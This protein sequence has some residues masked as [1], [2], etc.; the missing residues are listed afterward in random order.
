MLAAEAF[1]LP[2][3]ELLGHVVHAAAPVAALK[4]SGVHAVKLPPSGPVYPIEATQAVLAVEPV[5]PPLAEFLGQSKHAAAPVAALKVSVAHAVKLP[6]SGPV[7]PIEAL[8]AVLVE[9]LVTPSVAELLGHAEQAAAPVAALKESTVQA[10]GGPPSAPVNPVAALQAVLAV[11]PVAPSVAELLGHA[12]HAAEPVA[13]LKESA[14]HAVG[15]PPSAPVNPAAATQSVMAVE[16]VPVVNELSEHGV[17]DRVPFVALNVCST[18]SEQDPDNDVDPL[19]VPVYPA[20]HRQ[21]SPPSDPTG[22]AEFASHDTHTS[23]DCA[24]NPWNFPATHALHTESPVLVL[25]VP[26]AQAEGVLPSAPVYP[27]AAIQATLVVEPTGLLALGG[28]AV[29]G[30]PFGPVNPA[31]A[32]QS[33]LA[34]EPVP[35]VPELLGHA[36][37]AAAPVAALKEAA[38]HAVK[39]PPFGPV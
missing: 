2:V 16:P 34:V 5:A 29:N 26:A 3:P 39:L 11:E 30:P 19:R 24:V 32:T 37:H 9:E 21:S 6:P 15:T 23:D 38:A 12:M 4:E 31:A 8:Q 27:A 36:E 22:L 20:V 14:A 25:K 7:N 13:A 33:V 17:H 1:T 35:V 28:Q 18:H 10:V